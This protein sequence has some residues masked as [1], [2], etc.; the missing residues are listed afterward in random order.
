MLTSYTIATA[1]ALPLAGGLSDIFGRKG[2]FIVGCFISLVGTVIALAAQ[3]VPMVIA[4]MTFK[5]IGAG[6]QQLA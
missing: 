2:F 1:V 3:S 5:G 6:C 4:G